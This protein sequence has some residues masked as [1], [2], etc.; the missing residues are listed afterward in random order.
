MNRD[1][2]NHCKR[3]AFE[4][5]INYMEALQSIE[6]QEK[7]KKKERKYEGIKQLQQEQNQLV[8]YYLDKKEI[9]KEEFQKKYLEIQMQIKQKT[10]ISK[11]YR[12]IYRS[13]KKFNSVHM[14]A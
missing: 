4:N 2:T 1:W 3:Y 14:Q 10:D 6:C 7:Y 8:L 13:I 9:T 12:C 11:K 5:K